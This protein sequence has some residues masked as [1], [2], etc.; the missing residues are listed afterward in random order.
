MPSP[1]DSPSNTPNDPFIIESSQLSYPPRF[2]PVIH[3]TPE[4][5]D[6]YLK[7]YIVVFRLDPFTTHDG[8][9][10]RPV[11]ASARAHIHPEG[12]QSTTLE[13]Q[14]DLRSST[15]PAPE[16]ESDSEGDPASRLPPD[17]DDAIKPGQLR[18]LDGETAP[19]VAFAESPR[20]QFE[21]TTWSS[22]PLFHPLPQPSR[23]SFPQLDSTNH[24]RTLHAHSQ[25]DNQ[26]PFTRVDRTP[27]PEM[28]S[29]QHQSS[30]STYPHSLAHRTYHAGSGSESM[31]ASES[32]L[33]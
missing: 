33:E 18:Y 23:Q 5:H 24:P 16:S 31:Y 14:L 7:P 8:V 21:T 10:G 22:V 28:A 6:D 12:T 11:P 9:H 3:S 32:T 25:F 30:N 15:P 17:P 13:F 2:E 29:V 4:D 27:E 19:S 1:L 26:H 20:T